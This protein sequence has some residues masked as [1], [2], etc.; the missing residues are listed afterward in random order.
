MRTQLSP[1][2]GDPGGLSAVIGCQKLWSRVSGEWVREVKWPSIRHSSHSRQLVTPTHFITLT[3]RP[4]V[5]TRD[6][7]L[8]SKKKPQPFQVVAAV[9]DHI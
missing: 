1:G 2:L 4:Q 6:I 7:K 5:V 9:N 8:K 3:C